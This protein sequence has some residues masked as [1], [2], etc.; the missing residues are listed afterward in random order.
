MD[1]TTRSRI[2]HIFLSP[3]PSFA[4]LTAADRLG[5]TLKELQR[6]IEDGGIV[7]GSTRMGVRIGRA[8]MMAAAMR[9][10]EQGVIEEALG[11]DAASVLP[12]AIRLVEL[13]ERVP[14]YQREMLRVLARRD[15]TSIDDLLV[16]ELEDVASAHAEELAAVIRGFAMAMQWPVVSPA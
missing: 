2:R 5:M 10:W 9:V 4:L 15:R 13:R 14:W 1:E 11:D 6:E 7:A 8:E 16:R 12:A 3:R